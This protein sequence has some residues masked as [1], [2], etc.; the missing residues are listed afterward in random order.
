[1]SEENIDRGN[2]LAD[3]RELWKQRLNGYLPNKE[4]AE[5]IKDAYMYYCDAYEENLGR[6]VHD[7][8]RIIKKY[9]AARDTIIEL[10]EKSETHDI[11]EVIEAI[12]YSIKVIS[13]S[14]EAWRKESRK[15][16]FSILSGMGYNT[17]YKQ[18]Q[19]LHRFKSFTAAHKK[20][21]HDW[22]VN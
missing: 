6:E 13:T 11:E 7:R 21:K 4:E 20:L 17:K 10:F 18:D 8:N 12:N 3:A 2:Y 14:K 1:M 15:E 22:G 19:V 5:K 16:M 9:T